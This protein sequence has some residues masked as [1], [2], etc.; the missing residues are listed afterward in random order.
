MWRKFLKRTPV[1]TVMGYRLPE[2]RPTWQAALWMVVYLGLPLLLLGT[3]I[4]L[5]IQLTTGICT[6]L[7]CFF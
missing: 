4:D 6:G 5:A 2:P 7:W 3:L 1:Q